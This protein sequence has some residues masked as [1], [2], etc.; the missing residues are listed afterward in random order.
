MSPCPANARLLLQLQIKHAV[1]EAE[2]QQLKRKV[3]K[4]LHLPTS[5]LDPHTSPS[6]P[7]QRCCATLC[8]AVPYLLFGRAT[9]SHAMLCHAVPRCAIPALW[10]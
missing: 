4:F 10:P 1:T 9:P 3:S 8:H 2:I 5:P 7:T 6:W